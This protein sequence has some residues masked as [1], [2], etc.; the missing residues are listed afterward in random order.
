MIHE[1]YPRNIT[2]F[3]EMNM[4]RPGVVYEEVERVA[5]Q[6]LSK[7]QHPSVQKVRDI[8]GTGSNTTIANHLKLWQIS[9]SKSRSPTL[10]ESVPDDL[11]NPLDD[12][13]STAV[14][15]AEANYDKYKDELESKVVSAELAQSEAV[16][17]LEKKLAEFDIQQ[18]KLI[19]TQSELQNTEQKLHTLQ[20]EYSVLTNESNQI[21]NEMERALTLLKEQNEANK[22]EREQLNNSFNKTLKYEQERASATETRLLNEIDQLRQ[23]IKALETVNLKQQNEMQQLK[24]ISHHSELA[25]FQKQTELNDENSRLD[26]ECQRLCHDVNESKQH[27]GILQSQLTKSLGTVDSVQKSYEQSKNMEITLTNDIGQLKES[28]IS[29]QQ[30]IITNKHIK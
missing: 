2:T 15:R 27:L 13:W 11:M 3:K 19:D 26:I 5:R 20:G 16:G 25:L 29:L 8:L 18:Q 12:F 24:E 14:A 17:K 22:D 9:F 10:P 21:H 23:T 1:E 6:L 28:I 30:K 7:G 4:A